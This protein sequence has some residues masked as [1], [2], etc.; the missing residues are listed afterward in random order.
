MAEKRL[1][2]VVGNSAYTG[3]ASLKNPINDA[4]DIAKKLTSLKFDVSLV[5]NAD[6]RRMLTALD[7]FRGRLGASDIALIY[8]AGHGIA[9]NNESFLLPVDVTSEISMRHNDGEAA[10]IEGQTVSM[11]ALVAPLQSA[12][13]GIVILDACRN[14]PGKPTLGLNVVSTSGDTTVRRSVPIARGIAPTIVPVSSKGGV[15]RA[16]ATELGSESD[17]G[18]GRNSPFTT[19]LLRH[20]A[21]PGISIS[22]LMIRVR[23][24]VLQSTGNLQ[25]PWEEG[26]L[27]ESFYFAPRSLTAPSGPAPARSLSSA[28]RDASPV[29]RSEATGS[30]PRPSAPARA[31]MPPPGIGAGVG[32]GL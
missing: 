14:T 11:A 24:D 22:E 4:T 19:A 12:K 31:S 15:F 32:A 23:K 20:I 13:L 30:R 26:A 7:E 21:T 17:D 29:R 5:V 1:A 3:V 27:N 16:Y 25:R 10:T 2:L 18:D 8:Y 6:R 28:K 9:V